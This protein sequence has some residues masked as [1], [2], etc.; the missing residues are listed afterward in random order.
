MSNIKVN[1]T[2]LICGLENDTFPTLPPPPNPN[3]NPNPKPRQT[4]NNLIFT[5]EIFYILKY[6]YKF[7]H[8]AYI[9]GVCHSTTNLEDVIIIWSII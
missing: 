2:N 1:Y 7:M 3:P 9:R 5:N 8:T 6:S 4:Y